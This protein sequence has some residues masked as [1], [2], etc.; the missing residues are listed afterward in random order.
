MKKKKKVKEKHKYIF[1]N[2]LA[3]AMSKVDMRTQ[4]EASMLS[5]A[6]IL[7]G[8]ILTISYFVI[9]F[10]FPIWYK[11]VLAI[12]GV[13]GFVFISS[14]LV[15]AYQQYKTYMIALNFQKELEGGE[16][17]AVKKNKKSRARRRRL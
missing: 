14:F 3:K 11:I 9:Y 6:F 1:P 4:Y 12:N 10:S 16:Q 15:T 2:F 13:A 8:L 7:V 5:M 17:D